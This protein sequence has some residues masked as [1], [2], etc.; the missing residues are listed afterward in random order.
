MN[1]CGVLN[2]SLCKVFGHKLGMSD[3]EVV[4]AI[5]FFHILNSMLYYPDSG[6][7]DIVFCQP[8]LSH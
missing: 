6:A 4:S 5:K 7:D 8:S 1:R 3:E 2:L